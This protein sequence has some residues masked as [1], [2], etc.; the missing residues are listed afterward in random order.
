M[1]RERQHQPDDIGRQGMTDRDQGRHGGM[2]YDEDEME[3]YERPSCVCPKCGETMP[4]DN[5]T[6]C[7]QIACPKCGTILSEFTGAS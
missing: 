3:E 4:T 1:T 5:D 2:E 7:T 6:P